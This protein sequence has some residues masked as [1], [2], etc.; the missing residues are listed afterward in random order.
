M[1]ILECQAKVII[2]PALS[3]RVTG[4]RRV[5]SLIVQI[6]FRLFV[7]LEIETFPTRCWQQYYVSSSK[8]QAI[9]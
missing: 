1:C 5:L 2:R 6:L 4:I 7:F 9:V 8:Q 3:G